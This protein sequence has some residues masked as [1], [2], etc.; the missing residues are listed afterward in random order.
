M[1]RV[2]IESPYR[3]A[4]PRETELNVLYARAC[5]HDSLM[6]GEAPI[7]SHLL[8][9]QVLDDK[10]T[11]ER[12][13]GIAAG[14]AWIKYADAVC[15]YDDHGLSEGMKAGIRVAHKAKIPVFYR[16]LL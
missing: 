7:C 4:T 12:N 1:K 10:I 3:G 11:K 5:L 2:I 16:K 6:R 15:V 14:H 13:I 9:T 8:I